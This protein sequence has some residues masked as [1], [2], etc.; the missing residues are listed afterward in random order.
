[1]EQLLE[2]LQEIRDGIYLLNSNIEDF[3]NE[4]TGTG[5]YNSLSDV[6]DK[7]NNVESSLTGLT[8]Y[9]AYTLSDVCNKLDSIDTNTM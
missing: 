1:M 3:K 2:V 9:G 6:C 7:L 4:I 5:L 8:S